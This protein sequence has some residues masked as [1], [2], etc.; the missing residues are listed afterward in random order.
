MSKHEILT[1]Q[2]ESLCDAIPELQGVVLA[3]ADGLPIAH[4]LTNDADPSRV[5]AMA[6]A[7][8]NLGTRVSETIQAGTVG[9]V[10]IRAEEGDLY[11]YLVGGR[12]VLAVLG[13]KGANAGLI[14]LEARN[15]A[16][17]LGNLFT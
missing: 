14:H 3:S 16:D 1:K 2:I 8:A 11:V 6:V 5:A 17:A 13:P 7:A 12:A 4:S 10:S 9:E 15:T